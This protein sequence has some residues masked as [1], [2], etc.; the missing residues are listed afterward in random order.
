MCTYAV[1]WVG[2]NML[3]IFCSCWFL[4]F[5]PF[6]LPDLVKFWVAQLFLKGGKIW[7]FQ[8]F[9]D[10]NNSTRIDHTF[11]G[12]GRPLR[13]W[14]TPT[15]PPRFGS[16][17]AHARASTYHTLCFRQVGGK[18]GWP[19]VGTPPGLP[20]P[21]ITKKGESRQSCFC[22]FLRSFFERGEGA[23]HGWRG[24]RRGTVDKKFT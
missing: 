10:F 3:G 9:A 21:R 11:G 1:Q 2:K 12:T 24:G 19:G 22:S 14:S 15:A 8:V 20:H 7:S 16:R 23:G 6:Y 13:R 18:G 5:P 4:A 17:R